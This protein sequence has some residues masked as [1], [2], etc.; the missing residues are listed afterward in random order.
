MNEVASFE[1]PKKLEHN[2]RYLIFLMM[3][4]KICS[5]QVSKLATFFANNE[6]VIKLAVLSDHSCSRM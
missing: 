5:F 1:V 3:E 6:L 2:V 4:Q